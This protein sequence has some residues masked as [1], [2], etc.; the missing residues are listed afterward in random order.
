MA[1]QRD[2]YALLHPAPRLKLP[3]VLI[4]CVVMVVI[5]FQEDCFIRQVPCKGYTRDA[6]PRK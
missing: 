3:S 2:L 1:Q 4:G 5:V 6:E